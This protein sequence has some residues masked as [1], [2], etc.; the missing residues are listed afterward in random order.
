[1]KRLP[2]AFYQTSA[3]AQPVRDWLRGLS[4][5]DRKAIGDDIRTVEFGW[6][7][8][9]PTCRPMGDGLF[10]GSAASRL[11]KEVSEDAAKGASD[12]EKAASQLAREI[13]T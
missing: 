12:S 8:G 11:H 4:T 7:I 13:K 6:P 2:A 10:E 5:Q 3:G 1:M 9:M